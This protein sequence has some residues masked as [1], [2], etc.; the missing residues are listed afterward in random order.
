[1]PSTHSVVMVT[2][3]PIG[4]KNRNIPQKRLNEQ[5]YKNPEVLNEVLQWLLQPVTFKH[6]PGA[7][8]GYYNV[9]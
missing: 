1:M 6:N 4:F 5:R 9:L 7:E 3:L 2:L 8:S